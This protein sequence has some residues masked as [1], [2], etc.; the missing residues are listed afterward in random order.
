MLKMN[1]FKRC[2][3]LI[4]VSAFQLIAIL[5]ASFVFSYP[6]GF[7]DA[8]GRK[9]RIEDRPSRVV[10]LVP[11]ITEIIMGV[12]AGDTLKAITY[13]STYP[14]ETAHKVVIGGFFS[15]NLDRIEEI[16]PNLIFYS[17]LQKEVPERFTKSSCKLINLDM[18]SLA[19]SYRNILLIGKIFDVEKKAEGLVRQIRSKLELIAKKVE[20][21]PQ[22]KRKRVVRIMGLDPVMTPGDDSFQNEMI[23]AAGGIPPYL[24]KRGHVVPVTRKEWI[25]FN[26]QVIYGCGGDREAVASFLNQPDWKDVEAVKTGK[27]FDF[28]CDLTCRAATNTGD[29]VSWLSARIYE[30]Y[31]SEQEEQ[32]LRDSVTGFR[33]LDVPFHYV[34]DAR[35]VYSRIRDFPNKTLL[36]DFKRPL[37]VVSTLEGYRKG[38]ESIANHYSSTPCWILNHKLGL[39]GL[40]RLVY[41]VIGRSEA[42]TSGLL[43]GADMDNLSVKRKRHKEMEVYAFVTAGIKSNAV[44]MSKDTGRYYEPGTINII[45]LPNMHLTSRA[46]TRGIISATEAKTA[47]LMDMDIR[48]SFTSMVNQATGTGTDNIIVVEGEGQEIDNAGG[49]TKMGELI[50]KAVYEGVQ[51]AVYK[52]NGVI[53]KRNVFQRLMDRKI[54]VLGLISLDDCECGITKS[55]LAKALE[56]ILLQPRYASFITS[57]L[58]LSDSYERGLIDDLGPYGLWCRALAEE[59]AE[60]EIKDMIDLIDSE[61]MPIVIRMSLNSLLNGLYHKTR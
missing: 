52:Q 26:P 28:P 59:I 5:W 53:A 12:G 21:I 54:S 57:S 61:N 13:H 42:K 1:S 45:L 6:V 3:I 39:P 10:S 43:T 44:R 17:S 22:D 34:R 11:S 48:S 7:T 46:M 37:S 35:I 33:S 24:N 20:R 14:P 41:R 18:A 4:S 47:A 15:P 36:I 2:F 51:E 8:S 30:D 16:K 19:D 31:F 60:K 32:I 58:A 25:H 55:H 38:I 50:A 49:H 40:R 9:L 27:I 29:F 56:E 23:R